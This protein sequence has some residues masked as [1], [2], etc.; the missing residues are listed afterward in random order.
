MIGMISIFAELER[1]LTTKRVKKASFLNILL[2]VL[3]AWNSRYLEKVHRTV[4]T[5]D[6]FDEEQFKRV[7]P[8]G[9]GHVNFLGKYIFEEEK[10][11]SE[12]GL[13]PLKIKS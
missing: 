9:S 2:G 8:L 3:V 11:V 1:E 13:C 4:K 10:I 5:E 12:D 7:S 6:W